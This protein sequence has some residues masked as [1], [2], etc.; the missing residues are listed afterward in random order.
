MQL[1]WRAQQE[2]P[3]RDA[4][5]VSAPRPVTI[6]FHG[7]NHLS[8]SHQA[9]PEGNWQSR[10]C[11]W[12]QHLRLRRLREDINRPGHWRSRY[13]RGYL[14][15]A[16]DFQASSNCSQVIPKTSCSAAS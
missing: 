10:H 11:N 9:P 5:P 8:S 4:L 7:H 2:P 15:S 16:N 14:L 12:S 13:L 1:E 3:T 6:D